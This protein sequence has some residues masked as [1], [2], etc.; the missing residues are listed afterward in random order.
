MLATLLVFTIQIKQFFIQNIF[1]W[2]A[3]YEIYNKNIFIF[4]ISDYKIKQ[5]AF[6]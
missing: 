4:N 1:L 6:K 2:N 5:V 3:L